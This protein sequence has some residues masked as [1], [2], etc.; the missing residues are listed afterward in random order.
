LSSLQRLQ[1]FKRVSAWRL[2]ELRRL[3]TSTSPEETG[4][5][6]PQR[7]TTDSSR[8]V[9]LFTRSSGGKADQEVP[10]YNK[11]FAIWEEQYKLNVEEADKSLRFPLEDK[12][13]SEITL[14][15]GLESL[16]KADKEWVDDLNE[17]EREMEDQEIIEEWR[18]KKI[19]ENKKIHFE[20]ELSPKYGHLR[21]RYNYNLPDEVMRNRPKVSNIA[22]ERE[23]PQW[24]RMTQNFDT[25][26]YLNVTRT[27]AKLNPVVSDDKYKAEGL[28]GYYARRPIENMRSLPKEAYGNLLLNGAPSLREHKLDPLPETYYEP[29]QP[30]PAFRNQEAL[31]THDPRDPSSEQQPVSYEDEVFKFQRAKERKVK[32]QQRKDGVAYSPD[33]DFDLWAEDPNR[34]R[35]LINDFGFLPRKRVKKAQV[36]RKALSKPKKKVL[37]TFCPEWDNLVE[38]RY[39]ARALQ[40]MYQTQNK[41]PEFHIMK[42]KGN[43]RGCAGLGMGEGKNFKEAMED[44]DHKATHN[45]IWIPRYR[46]RGLSHPLLGRWD[47]ACI[48]VVRPTRMGKEVNAIPPLIKGVCLAFGVQDVYGLFARRNGNH[49]T[50][51]KAVWN[52]FLNVSNAQMTCEDRGQR[53]VTAFPEVTNCS[54]HLPRGYTHDKRAEATKILDNH[55]KTF[56]QEDG[57][58]QFSWTNKEKQALPEWLTKGAPKN[59]CWTGGLPDISKYKWTPGIVEKLLQI[60]PGGIE[61]ERERLICEELRKNVAPSERHF[62]WR[63]GVYKM[64]ALFHTKKKGTKLTL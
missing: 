23:Y 27:I 57:F 32:Y 38:F 48:A 33:F 29:N 42:I 56:N 8:K 26:M 10:K 18:R 21:Q 28:E 50:Q 9:P 36:F 11:Y 17:T 62:R 24:Y 2:R 13:N 46:D 58:D 60:G 3:C 12:D 19:R 49:W 22:D 4:S 14:K 63:A 47:K 44:A 31:F 34:P 55:I 1:N 54:Y 43:S 5:L 40:W 20:N 59:D 64:P 25:E 53:V 15:R 39:K 41:Q 16:E 30:T 37:D 6:P 61:P 45:M 35:H 51:M 7:H 52:A